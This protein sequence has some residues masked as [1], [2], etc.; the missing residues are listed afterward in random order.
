M[1]FSSHQRMHNWLYPGG[2]GTK[3]VEFREIAPEFSEREGGK[4]LGKNYLSTPDQDS[5]PKLPVTGSTVSLEGDALDY[6]TIKAGSLLN[7]HFGFC[8]ML[9]CLQR[10]RVHL[11]TRDVLDDAKLRVT[12][13]S[14]SV[15]SLLQIPGVFTVRCLM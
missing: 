1:Y 8:S 11:E 10:Y 7:R 15:R 3:K 13:Q 6:S 4:L 5:K 14:S 12:P 9:S 2:K